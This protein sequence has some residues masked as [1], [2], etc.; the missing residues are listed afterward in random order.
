[1]RSL[2]VRPFSANTWQIA[3]IQVFPNAVESRNYSFVSELIQGSVEE[4]YGRQV[5]PHITYS[6]QIA[7]ASQAGN[8]MHQ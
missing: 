1:M 7:H 3:E 4:I 5:L 8:G 6:S 2:K